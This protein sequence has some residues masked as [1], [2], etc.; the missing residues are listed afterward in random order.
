MLILLNQF[1]EDRVHA[2]VELYKHIP[3]VKTFMKIERERNIMWAIVFRWSSVLLLTWFIITQ[4]LFIWLIHLVHTS[5]HN[6]FKTPISRLPCHW[7]NDSSNYVFYVILINKYLIKAMQSLH[8]S[9][10]RLFTAEHKEK[11]FSP[12]RT[13]K[14]WYAIFLIK[15]KG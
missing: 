11:K 8:F 15:S 12:L 6:S 5:Y 14:S 13:I 4:F 3:P 2:R 1:K 7:M 10:K 9:V